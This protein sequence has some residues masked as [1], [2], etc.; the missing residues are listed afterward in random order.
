MESVM[1][2]KQHLEW[3]YEQS[4]KDKT[5]NLPP[6][7]LYVR[8]KGALDWISNQ[9]KNGDHMKTKTILA[10]IIALALSGCALFNPALKDQTTTTNP[11]GNIINVGDGKVFG[12]DLSGK[13]SQIFNILPSCNEEKKL[14]AMC[15]VGCIDG[16][17][18][19]QSTI[20][21]VDKA[22]QDA[23]KQL[24][25]SVTDN[26]EYLCCKSMGIAGSYL[27]NKYG[28]NISSITSLLGL[29]K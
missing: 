22:T 24:G 9:I 21:P 12:I 17:T 14:T 19:S 4:E 26:E 5:D 27:V 29:V 20:D 28:G 10:L 11:V 3:L 1:T 13:I 25:L 7:F 2:S 8:L 23:I 16:I 18:G 6:F 15:I